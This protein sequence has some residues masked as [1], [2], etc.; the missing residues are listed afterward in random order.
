VIFATLLL[1]AIAQ[2][3]SHGLQP[4]D[5]LDHSAFENGNFDQLRD[6]WLK[7]LEA[8]PDSEWTAQACRLLA[9]FDRHCTTELSP[10]RLQNLIDQVHN[11]TANFQLR[12]LWARENNRRMFRPLA[13]PSTDDLYPDF[14]REWSTIGPFGPLDSG[15]PL[16]LP[17]AP[18]RP[19]FSLQ[20][21]YST[22]YGPSL[23]WS[24][25]Q[26]KPSSESVGPAKLLYP[27]T[28]V[29]YLLTFLK[30]SASLADLEIRH[31][32]DFDLYWNGRLLDR[33]RQLQPADLAYRKTY[34]VSLDDG[35]WNALLIRYSLQDGPRFGARLLAENRALP[36]EQTAWVEDWSKTYT[37]LPN[38]PLKDVQNA[39]RPSDPW[40]DLLRARMDIADGRCDLALQALPMPDT[41]LRAQAPELARSQLRLRHM[42]LRKSTHLPSEVERRESLKVESQLEQMG[43]SF[44]RIELSKINRLLSEDRPEDALL[45]AQKLEISMPDNPVVTLATIEAWQNL[46]STGIYAQMATVQAHQRFPQNLNLIMLLQ[47][48]A[49]EQSDISSFLKLLKLAV[50]LDGSV[51]YSLSR[52]IPLL[53]GGDEKAAAEADYYLDRMEAFTPQNS[54]LRLWRKRQALARGNSAELEHMLQTAV[55]KRAHLPTAHAALADYY[56]R[57]GLKHEAYAAIQDYLSVHPGTSRYHEALQLIG[58]STQAEQFFSEFAPD[59]AAALVAGQNAH[60]AST[61]LV[62]D[63]GMI[64]FYPDGSSHTRTHTITK[65]LDRKGTEAL[66][67]QQV[68]NGT[69]LAQVLDAEGGT[70]EPVIVEQNWVMPSL[71]PGDSVEL[72]VDRHQGGVLGSTPDPGYWRFASFRQPFALS[73]YVVYIPDGLPGEWREFQFNG[74]REQIRWNDGMVYLYTSHNLPRFQEEPLRPSDQEL[75]PWVQYGG[76]ISLTEVDA[77]HRSYAAELQAV[78]ADI[79]A[80]LRL[81]LQALPAN[82]NPRIRAASIYNLVQE[83]VLDFADRGDVTDVW[84]MKRGYPLGLLA[85]LYRLDGIEFEWAVLNPPVAPEL[86]SRPEHI[87][88]SFDDFGSMLLRLSPSAETP[89]PGWL[90]LPYDGRGFPFLSL[91][92]QLAGAP[93]VVFAADESRFENLPRTALEESWSLDLAVTYQLQADGAAAVTGSMAMTNSDGPL[94]REQIRQVQPSQRSQAARQIV[95]QM[96]PGID[97]DRWKFVDLEV[98]GAPFRFEFNGKVPGFVLGDGAQLGCRLRIPP[99]QLSTGL[100]AADRDWPLAFRSIMGARM[101][102]RVEMNGLY[103]FE[104]GPVDTLQEREGYRYDFQVKREADALEV[105]RVLRISGMWLEPEE[106]PA[107]LESARK[108]EQEE[109]RAV[110]LTRR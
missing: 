83:H 68:Q 2:S 90:Y 71:D 18:D 21:E 66:H 64:F 106:V 69:R 75:L 11:P 103:D 109:K 92:D 34:R 61:A 26:R 54:G 108:Y 16:E 84:T 74:E 48:Y 67:E 85:A 53:L 73:R 30:T 19:V 44:V 81:A 80:E 65:A 110:R 87:F 4:R 49:A 24:A 39:V 20:P 57:S 5:L 52:L 77:I 79:E 40:A 89:E 15:A 38:N 72:I 107:F 3:A 58:Q 104:Y 17:I 59:R 27:E 1:A 105:Q 51:S 86:D 95:S 82:D 76:D 45:L 36:F 12:L 14:V 93:V 7:A 102:V 10:Q 60:D 97:L 70:Y 50:E 46:D 43:H 55:K 35:Q 32:G 78:P 8:D 29:G 99:L 88:K 13:T 94:M 47:D 56:L 41:T 33:R 37:S 63:S 42:A 9:Q 62:L 28:G 101:R 23:K 100:G 96:V 91:P 98:S 6:D 25:I 31:A 22:T